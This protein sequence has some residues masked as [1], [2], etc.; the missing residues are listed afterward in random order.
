M[1][2]FLSYTPTPNEKH[3]G[4][5]SV[6]YAGKVVLRYKIVPKKDGSA[7]FPTAASYKIVENG[8]D[9]YTAA[10]MLDSHSE[11]EDM[12]NFIRKHVTAAMKPAATAS[13][14]SYVSNDDLPF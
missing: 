3:L 9:R 13:V 7:W 2:E 5:A 8:E 10:F 4:I 14:T 6:K 11:S 12:M 1:F